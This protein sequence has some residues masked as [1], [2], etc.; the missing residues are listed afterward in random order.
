MLKDI[1]YKVVYSSGEDEPI[2]FFIDSLLESNSFDLGL[3]F[4]SSSGFRALSV[5]VAC[6]INH[7]GKMRILINDVLS[8]ED[9]DAILKGN[10]VPAEELIEENIINDLSKFYEVLSGHDKHFFNCIS[11]MIATQKIEFRAIVPLAENVGIAHQKFGLFRDEQKSTIAFSGS[12][13]FSVN[14]LRNNIETV[15]CYKSWTS[16][17][18]E[19]ARIEHFE[20]LFNKIWEGRAE[21]I[22]IIPIQKVKTFI[23]DKFPTHSMDELLIEEIRLAQDLKT[24]KRVSPAVDYKLSELERRIK[25][26][27]LRPAFPNGFTPWPYQEDA[28]KNWINS[29]YIGF[30]EMATGTGKTITA[31]NCALHLYNEEGHI[32]SLILVPSLSLADQWAKEAESFNF[33]NI[34]IANSKNSNWTEEV[35]GQLNKSQLSNSSFVIITTYAT[36]ALEKFQSVINK[37]KGDTLFIADEAHNFGTKKLIELHPTKFTRRIGLSATPKR[38][39]DSDGTLAILKYFGSIEKPTF[40]LDMEEAI[41]KGFLCEYYYF[42]KIVS[43]TKDELEEYKAISKKLLKYFD[44]KRGAFKDNPIVNALLLKRKRIIH[45]AENKKSCLKEC[46]KEI[47]E[48][49]GD[50]KYTLVYVPEGAD[51]EIDD[52]DKNLIDEYSSI[53]ANDFGVSQ[54]QFIGET[55]GRVDILN[56]FAQGKLNVLTAM[57]CLDEGVDVKR[58]EVAVFC[59]STGNPR[60]FIQRRG[61]I[62]RLHPEKRN[63]TIFD[64]IAIPDI[65]RMTGSNSISMEKSILRAELKRVYEFAS[66]SK[67]KYQALKTL[68]TVAEEFDIDIFSTEIS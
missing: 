39:F 3:G 28:L 5:G 59:S 64:M 6:F 38:H 58:T 37:L 48:L 57:K 2:E 54:H 26:T 15:S 19:N 52:F 63:A 14:A 25:G 62:L 24:N 29:N 13:N 68:E 18:S 35:I 21:N 7:G 45:K 44:S 20:N 49:K 12:A 67:N 32:R 53:I 8:P 42:P 4:F 1:D 34:I 56:R 41:E 40:K 50:I 60:Q 43:L 16:E 36:Y 46:L 30:F 10:S 17:K 22:R 33:K 11:W 23:R 65:S 51:N 9:K 27:D 66:L 55:D 31:L 47:M 61:R